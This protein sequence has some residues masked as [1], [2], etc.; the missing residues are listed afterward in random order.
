MG[1]DAPGRMRSGGGELDQTAAGSTNFSPKNVTDI[2]RNVK[3]GHRNY[4]NK[5]SHLIANVS[6]DIH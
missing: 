5:I 1:D 4:P 3:F 2:Q 6:K